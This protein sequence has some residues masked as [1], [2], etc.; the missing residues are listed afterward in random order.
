MTVTLKEVAA[1]AGV[2]RS[3]VSRTFTEG[4]SV[5][6]KTRRK[7]ERAAEELG[8]RPSLIARSLATNRTRLIGL[9]A[10]NFRN[11]VFLEVFDLFTRVLQERGFRPLLVNLSTETD[12]QKSLEMLKQ[13]RVDGIIIATS[14]LP[15]TFPNAFRK[16]GVPV[17]HAFGRFGSEAGLHIVGIDNV[18]C[19]EMAAQTLVDRGYRNIALLG[20]PRSATST[21]DRLAGFLRRLKKLGLEPTD[22]RFAENYSYSAGREA[23]NALLTEKSVEALFCGDD[24]I[25]MGAMDAARGAGL[26]IPR[27][28][29]FLGFNDMNMAGWSTY[30]LT[31]IRQPVRDIILQSVALV[32]EMVDDP[33]KESDTQPFPCSIVERSTLRPLP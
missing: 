18:R 24:L 1:R 3:A 15:P 19:G 20:G 32:I 28:I 21:Q 4:A 22:I 9:V 5:S 12:P 17:V 8:Y 10:N 33:N 16:A 30:D 6:D 26:E 13:Y 23:M 31:T 25:C 14:T 7:V 11:P 27:D 2:S 29:G